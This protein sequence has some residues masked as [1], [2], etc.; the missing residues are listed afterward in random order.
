MLSGNGPDIVL[1]A[2]PSYIAPMAEAGQL[3]ALDSYAAKYKWTDPCCRP[4]YET[5]KI[6]RQAVRPAQDLRV[7]GALLQQ[8]AV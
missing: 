5:G 7:D 2:G 4:I 6:E 1:T 3:L 8:V